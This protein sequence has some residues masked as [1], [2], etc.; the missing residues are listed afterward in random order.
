MY[1]SKFFPFFAKSL[2]ILSMDSFEKYDIVSITT[3]VD[4]A[5]ENLLGTSL[6]EKYLL[7]YRVGSLNFVLIIDDSFL[8]LLKSEY[9]LI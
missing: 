1:C 2:L 4:A 6:T 7:E 9:F 5:S 8:F 3:C